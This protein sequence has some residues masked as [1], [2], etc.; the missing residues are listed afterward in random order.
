M[1]IKFTILLLIVST[2]AQYVQRRL[3]NI[4]NIQKVWKSRPYLCL[5]IINSLNLSSIFEKYLSC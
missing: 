3:L 5:S 4:N 2:F 1:R